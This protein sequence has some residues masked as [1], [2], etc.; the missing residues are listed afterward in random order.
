MK[1]LAKVWLWRAVLFR[2]E[3]KSAKAP[4]QPFDTAR[5]NP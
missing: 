4:F 5:F 3:K 2:G 1:G